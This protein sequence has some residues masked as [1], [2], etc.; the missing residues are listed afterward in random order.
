MDKTENRE[1]AALTN[2][3]RGTE[4]IDRAGSRLPAVLL[5]GALVAPLV[6]PFFGVL[7]SLAT[8]ALAPTFGP[9]VWPGITRRAATGYAWLALIAFWVLPIFSFVG[10]GDLASGWFVIP[11][12]GPANAAAWLIPAGAAFLVYA[13]GC[14]A[15]VRRLRPIWWVAGAALSMVSYEAA[16]AQLAASG[17]TWVC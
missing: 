8:L 3:R 6:L 13:S 2:T 5:F 15:S 16:W 4:P 9:R 17:D 12:C 10:V 1:P 14:I 7:V 11:L